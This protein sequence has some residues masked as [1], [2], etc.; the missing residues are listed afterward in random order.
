[1][2][3]ALPA[4]SLVLIAAILAAG[5]VLP[6]LLPVYFLYL[7][8]ALMMYAVLRTTVEMFRGDEERGRIFGAFASVPRTAWYNISTSQ[9][10]SLMIF[11]TGI[12]IW[13]RFGR[14]NAGN[15]DAGGASTAAAAA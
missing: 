10:V 15:T 2:H 12:V 9:F 6:L 5:F 13:A 4:R 3:G 1:M 7:A 14:A 8:N 11:A